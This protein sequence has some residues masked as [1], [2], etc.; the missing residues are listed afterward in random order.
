MSEWYYM[1]Y[2]EINGAPYAARW[3][4]C[5][6]LIKTLNDHHHIYIYLN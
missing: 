1:E 5:I 2:I 4:L 6:F 3:P